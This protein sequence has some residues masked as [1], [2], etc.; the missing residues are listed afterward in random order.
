MTTK[1]VETPAAGAPPRLRMSYEEYLAWADEDTH[2]EWVNGEVIVHMPATDAHQSIIGFLQALLLLYVT[3]LK[4]GRV[5]TAPFPMRLETTN[6]Q[7]EPDIS[8]VLND[9]LSC[10]RHQYIDGPA[11][12]VVE[13]I[14]DESVR[15]DRY[16]KFNEYR[17]AAVPEYWIIDSRQGR[18]RADFYRLDERDEYELFAT[19]DDERVESTVLKGFWLR[20]SWLWGDPPGDVLQAYLEIRGLTAGQIDQIDK[21]L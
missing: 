15:R 13:I 5:F 21:L 11:D 12:L 3:R 9:H 8:V 20:P 18:M 2:A 6:S 14:S 19:E 16:E 7:R 17:R 1:E 4:L 10:V